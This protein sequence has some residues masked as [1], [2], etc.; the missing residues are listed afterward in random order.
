[1]ASLS[2][3]ADAPWRFRYGVGPTEK[4][5]L[6]VTGGIPGAQPIRNE[7]DVDREERRASGY[8]FAKQHPTI[9]PLVQPT[10][11]DLRAVAFRDDP[12][13]IAAAQEGQTAALGAPPSGAGHGIRTQVWRS[14]TGGMFDSWDDARAHFFGPGP[15]RTA[16]R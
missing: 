6:A 15:V 11:D 14:A 3:I 8:L 4:Y 2:D 10:V 7:A 12:S 1:M 9:A 16:G 13:V 5:R